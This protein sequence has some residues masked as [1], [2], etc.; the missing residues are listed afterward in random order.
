MTTTDTPKSA[1][2]IRENPGVWSKGGR[3]MEYLHVCRLCGCYRTTDD[4]GVQRNPDEPLRTVTISDRDAKSEA[5]LQ[6]QHAE[7]GWLP[8]WLCEMLECSPTADLGNTEA[9]NYV[10]DHHDYDEHDPEHLE[11]VFAALY[12]RRADDSDRADG[13]WSLCCAGV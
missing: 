8:E 3:R 2:G 12:G 5:W 7:H 11:H 1:P 10:E 9:R 6:E 4:P 13:L